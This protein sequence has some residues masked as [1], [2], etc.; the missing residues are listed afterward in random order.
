MFRSYNAVL[1]CQATNAT[2]DVEGNNMGTK[3]LPYR[4]F[5][6]NIPTPP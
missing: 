1:N 4:M 5:V 3:N 2:E 6:N